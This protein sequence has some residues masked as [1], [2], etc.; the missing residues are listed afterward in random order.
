MLRTNRERRV[1]PIARAVRATFSGNRTPQRLLQWL[2]HD[3]HSAAAEFADDAEVAEA[4]E[5]DSLAIGCRNRFSI[6]ICAHGGEQFTQLVGVFRVCGGV[7]AHG[8]VFAAPNAVGEF[9]GEQVYRIAVI[10]RGH[11]LPTSARRAGTA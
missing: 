11:M 3:A 2:Q 9:L 7:I 6:S 5:R 8:R 10:G 1:E 4:F